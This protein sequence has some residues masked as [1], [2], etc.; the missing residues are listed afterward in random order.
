MEACQACNL[1]AI[2][3]W[4]ISTKY[5][6]VEGCKGKT[7]KTKSS[8]GSSGDHHRHILR[9]NQLTPVYLCPYL[10]EGIYLKSDSSKYP[11]PCIKHWEEANFMGDSSDEETSWFN[12]E[13]VNVKGWI[14]QT[15]RL[16]IL[17]YL[18]KV[19]LVFTPAWEISRHVEKLRKSNRG[20]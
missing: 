16:A 12:Q 1:S 17:E 19:I 11:L 10:I 15:R 14:L 20:I 13:Q 6:G 8:C 18:P 3:D 2:S 7:G 4:H 5:V 9:K